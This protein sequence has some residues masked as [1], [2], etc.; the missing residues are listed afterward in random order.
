MRSKTDSAS[1]LAMP[2]SAITSAMARSTYT[3]FNT[4]L[5]WLATSP[6]NSSR[7]SSDVLGESSSTWS[8]AARAWVIETPSAVSTS[9]WL[10]TWFVTLASKVSMPSVYG[11]IGSLVP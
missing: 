1:V 7:V 3:R 5:I 6:L 10:S 9:A 8:I 2:K 4:L 11:P